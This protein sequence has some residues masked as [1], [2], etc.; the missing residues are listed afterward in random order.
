MQAQFLNIDPYANAFKMPQ[1]ATTTGIRIIERDDKVPLQVWEEKYEIDSLANFLKLSHSYWN[2][3]GDASFVQDPVWMSA[4][5]KVI[6]TIYE[7]QEPTYDKSG[8][9]LKKKNWC[10]QNKK[11][12]CSSDFYPLRS[13]CSRISL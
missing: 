2:T 7:Q 12:D 3:T 1:N 10:A 5:H 4:V 11:L 9:T 6:K 13:R 8:K